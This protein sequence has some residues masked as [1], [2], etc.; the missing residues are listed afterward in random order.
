M[1]QM[2]EKFTTY[3]VFFTLMLQ[4]NGIFIKSSLSHTGW[5]G[6]PQGVPSD[7]NSFG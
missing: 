7:G 3:C 5:N 6:T 4:A 1:P 2:Y